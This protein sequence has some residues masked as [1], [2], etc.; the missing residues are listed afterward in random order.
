M[1]KKVAER[2]HVENAPVLSL[3]ASEGSSGVA[4]VHRR[5]R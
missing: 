5:R 3:S 4:A 1:A 2:L